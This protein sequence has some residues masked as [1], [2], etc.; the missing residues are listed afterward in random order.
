MSKL[1]C[2]ILDDIS[3]PTFPTIPVTNIYTKW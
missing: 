3:S 1:D 2:K